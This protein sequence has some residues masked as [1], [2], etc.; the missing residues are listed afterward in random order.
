GQG[1]YRARKIPVTVYSQ[2]QGLRDRNVY[3][4]LE[5]HTGAIWL[6]CWP[7][8]L[9]RFEYG[10]FTHYTRKDGLTGEQ[11]TSLYEDRSR[12]LWVGAYGDGM[13]V[14]Q[15]G[16]FVIPRG[17][18]R[19]RVVK[20]I[21]QD[22][23]GA[24][25]FGTEHELVRYK[26]G[27]ATTYTT[28]DGL[29]SSDVRVLIE[30]A[31]GDVWIGGYQGLTR[32]HAGQFT[33]YTE[34][35]G[36]PSSNIRALYQDAQGVLWI[37]TYD[38]GLGRFQAGK[39]TR[40]TIRE[41]LFNN[42]VFQIL[43]DA[44]GNLW[45]SS[46]LGIYRVSKKELNEFAAGQ[47]TSVTSI[48]YGKGDGLRNV[49]CNG[50][51][52]PA[53]AKARDGKL[54]FPTQDGVAVINPDNLPANQTPPPVIIESCL[55]D[56]ASVAMD[57]GVRVKPGQDD[58]EIHYTALS[59]MNSDRI[60]FRYILEGLDSEWVEAG[61]RRTVYYSHLPPGHYVFR[62]IAANSDGVWNTGGQTLSLAVMAPF[63]RT[64]WFT[65]LAMLSAAALVIFVWQY[66][67]AEWKRARAA[68]L[69][70]SRQLIA[71]QES[72]RKR[73]AAELHDSL[74]QSLAILRNRALLSLQEPENHR[75]AL[76]QLDEIAQGTSDA[77]DELKQIAYHLRPH[78]LERLGLSKSIEVMLDEISRAEEISMSADLDSVDTLLSPEAQI[79]I[80]RI[81]QESAHNIV[82]HAQ[83]TEAKLTIRRADAGVEILVQDNGRGFTL[84]EVGISAKPYRG[85]GLMGMAERARM[86]GGDLTIDSKPGKG[87]TLKIKV[88][89]TEGS[90][91]LGKPVF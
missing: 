45:M 12:R 5:D 86:L 20:A 40:Y 54:W 63:Y 55:V 67:V 74:G 7:G 43:E 44:R 25:W 10:R 18:P 62:V 21:L 79:N 2:S 22:R 70:F 56:R 41:G 37:G 31:A 87:T 71:S 53:G 82:K 26:N 75:R 28:Q 32:F 27:V 73:V 68:Q 36:L 89:V 4:V 34:R 80:Y 17:P 81:V 49:E 85:F 1:L 14:F 88:A 51:H 24:F 90:K 13:R 38:G 76:E 23:Q 69:A 33:A 50:G 19:L 61:T 66:R 35:D 60:R 3:T 48:A 52:W 72:E 30:D 47:R 42:G 9:S 8:T 57:G 78:H 6:G 16:H 58:I 59:L 29:A 84:E 77:I 91:C 39:C 83:A 46:N 65:A 11:I 15:D 64:W